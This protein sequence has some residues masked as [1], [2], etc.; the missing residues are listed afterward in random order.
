MLLSAALAIFGLTPA[1]RAATAEPVAERL[2]N[3][4]AVLD[5]IMAAPD[6]GIP[7]DLLAKAECVAVI[8]AE[9][10]FAFIVGG[11]YGRGE[12]SCRTGADHRGPWSAPLMIS[13]GGGS[14]GFQIG[15]E[16]TDVILLIMND[17]GLNHLLSS[18]FTLGADASVAAGPVGRATSAETDAS[19][20]AEILSYSRNRGVFAG[21]SLKGAVVKPDEESNQLLYGK[22]VT[23]RQILIEN[24]V[25]LPAAARP[26]IAALNKYA[27]PRRTITRAN[28]VTSVQR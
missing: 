6:K 17:R 24:T 1:M 4:A 2:R 18:K 3:G 12:V 11:N 28:P 16:S 7:Q 5:E 8:P 20:G 21:V 26:F 22:P 15:G 25:P 10:K 9:K 14:F 19:M 23:A 13:V 27:P